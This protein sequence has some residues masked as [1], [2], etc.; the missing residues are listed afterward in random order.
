MFCRPRAVS[1]AV[2]EDLIQTYDEGIKKG[3]WQRAQLNEYGTPVVPI[4]KPLLG[5]QS[6]S[7]LRVCGD[8]SMTVDAQLEA[9]RHPLPTPEKV[10]QKLSVC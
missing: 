6:K 8:Y 9:H 7:N 3:V 5:G 1:F 2:Q 4:R 10:V